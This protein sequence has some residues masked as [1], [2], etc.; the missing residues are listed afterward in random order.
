VVTVSVDLAADGCLLS[1]GATGHAGDAL[2][3][4]NI[5]C[6]A[7]TVLLRTTARVLYSAGAVEPGGGAEAPGRLQLCVA[8]GTVARDWLQ[9]VTDCLLRGVRDL[10]A[11]FPREVALVIR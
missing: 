10:A 1:L 6:A 11:E 7:V 4:A 2:A 9:G 8:A 5:A 3:G